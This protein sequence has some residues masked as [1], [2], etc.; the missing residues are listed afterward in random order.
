VF[1]DDLL[2]E[3]TVEDLPWNKR[4]GRSSLESL[5]EVLRH[6]V[7]ARPCLPRDRDDAR[8]GFHAT[9]RSIH[10]SG[11]RLN[12]FVTALGGDRA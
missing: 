6:D 8:M 5:R 3:V 4:A 7:S 11:L 1:L 12:E 9:S 10:E 2:D